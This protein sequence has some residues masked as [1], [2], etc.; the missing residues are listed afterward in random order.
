MDNAELLAR[1][2]PGVPVTRA[3]NPREALFSNAK[4]REVLGFRE[5]HRWQD[6]VKG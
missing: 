3:L 4:I 1:F 5:D 2:F 6:Y